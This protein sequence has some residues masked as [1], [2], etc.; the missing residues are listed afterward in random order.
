MKLLQERNELHLTHFHLGGL[1]YSK[2][3]TQEKQL[4]FRRKLILLERV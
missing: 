3:R 2:Y 4:V 1:A